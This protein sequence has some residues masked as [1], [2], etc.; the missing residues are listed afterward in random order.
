[1]MYNKKTARHDIHGNERKFVFKKN[2][3]KK[4]IQENLR[5]KKNNKKKEKLSKIFPINKSNKKKRRRL[6]FCTIVLYVSICIYMHKAHTYKEV[7]KY[8][9]SQVSQRSAFYLHFVLMVLT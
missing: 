4:I 2:E 8:S 1:M 5:C 9:R 6:N 7:E 3:N